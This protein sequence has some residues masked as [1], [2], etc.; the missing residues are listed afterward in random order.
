MD[1]TLINDPLDGMKTYVNMLCMSMALMV[2]CQS[3][4]QLVVL[5][6][7]CRG[8]LDV[9]NLFDKG[10]KP[11]GF[12]CCVSHCDILT[13]HCGQKYEIFFFFHFFDH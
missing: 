7:G 4:H 13:F 10:A 6:K 11:E 1:G 8:K 3:N 5:K 2:L 12:L 9:K